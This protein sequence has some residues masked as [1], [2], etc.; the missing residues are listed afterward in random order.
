MKLSCSNCGDNVVYNVNG[1]NLFCP[2]CGSY[3]ELPQEDTWLNDGKSIEA[4]KYTCSSCGN[5]ILSLDDSPI[6]VC[7][8][9]GSTEFS[10]EVFYIKNY[11][12]K[13][14]PFNYSKDAFIEKFKEQCKA[15]EYTEL[16]DFSEKSIQSIKG[17]YIPVSY[18]EYNAVIDVEQKGN[19]TDSNNGNTSRRGEYN[20]IVPFDLIREIDDKTISGIHPFNYEKKVDFS[21]YYFAGFSSAYSNDSEGKQLENPERIIKESLLK[22]DIEKRLDY[23]IKGYNDNGEALLKN[24]SISCT[25]NKTSEKNS[26]YVPVWLCT[27]LFRDKLYSFA[28]NGETGKIVSSLPVDNKKKKKAIGKVKREGVT[29]IILSISAFILCGLLP[30]ILVYLLGH[31]QGEDK[32]TFYLLFFTIMIVIFAFFFLILFL[33]KDSLDKTKDNIRKDIDNTSDYNDRIVYKNIFW[34]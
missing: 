25:I 34:K 11:I 33:T 27:Y 1:K 32:Y 29:L 31:Y 7:N 28:M 13:V 16:K 17:I 18:D 15:S 3:M 4:Q 9:C 30:A 23:A 19:D 12:N 21:P 6:A 10:K 14:I 22:N 5:Q 8:Y 20:V 24:G 26:V 2:A